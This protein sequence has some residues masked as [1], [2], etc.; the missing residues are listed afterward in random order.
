MKSGSE[1]SLAAGAVSQSTTHLPVLLLW[2]HCEL[3]VRAQRES[4][5]LRERRPLGAELKVLISFEELLDLVLYWFLQ[6]SQES[7]QVALCC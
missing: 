7:T 6:R 3:K 4:A 1:Q 5:P 2:A